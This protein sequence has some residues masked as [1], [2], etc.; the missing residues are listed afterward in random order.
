MELRQSDLRLAFYRSQ[1]FGACG[2]ARTAL[3][4]AIPTARVRSTEPPSPSR[5]AGDG[6]WRKF[7]GRS[8][9]PAANERD[10]SRT[11]SVPRCALLRVRRFCADPQALLPRSWPDA[12]WPTGPGAGHPAG[13][14]P[15]KGAVSCSAATPR[16]G[17]DDLRLMVDGAGAPAFSWPSPKRGMGGA[18]G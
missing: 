6:R 13:V 10:F 18:S 3:Y 17:L 16:E 7:E 5:P 9:R 2:Q 12:R 1:S 4:S 8:W 14:A 15:C 11:H